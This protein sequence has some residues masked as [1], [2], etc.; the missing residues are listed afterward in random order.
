MILHLTHKPILPAVDGGCVAM[1]ELQIDLLQ[2]GY[3]VKYMS[4]ATHKHPFHPE[5]FDTTRKHLV[6][7]EFVTVDTSVRMGRAL[8][9]FLTRKSYNLERFYSLEFA[10]KLEEFLR[11]NHVSAVI[12]DSLYT[13]V[14]LDI[15]RKNGPARCILRA[16]N[17]EH[18][19]WEQQAKS[20]PF[21]KRA[22]L[23]KLANDLRRV[24]TTLVQAMDQVWAIS[25]EDA[26]RFESL[27]PRHLA[28]IPV[29]IKA[30]EAIS[31]IRTSLFFLGSMNWEPNREA[32]RLI[33]HVILPKL[34]QQRPVEFHVA[35]SFS[36][37][38]TSSSPATTLHGHV[39]SSSAFMRSHGI[40]LAP[41]FSGSGVRIKI[42][43]AM[44]LGI[45][46]IS[47]P[48]GFQGIPVTH[49]ENAWIARS[50]DDF[51]YAINH[52]FEQPQEA[53]AMGQQAQASIQA[54]F[55][56]EQVIHQIVHQLG[57]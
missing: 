24:E 27:N 54:H 32:Y 55:G 38:V 34:N 48:L 4:L 36:E 39:A 28:V 37:Q 10:R 7:P 57:Q 43:E 6:N 9:S 40:L 26:Q 18:Q 2:A 11:K 50:I 15:V 14:Y 33:D 41:Y 22:I 35:G 29:A 44:N 1:N 25:T 8:F 13:A 3:Q 53:L 47:T 31:E 56:R 17:V 46:V 30:E 42:L 19:L 20:A 23:Q 21:W 49:R 52:L 45:P 12:F 5:A 51:V 16:H